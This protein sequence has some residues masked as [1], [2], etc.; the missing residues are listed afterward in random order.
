LHKHDFDVFHYILKGKIKLVT[1]L[2]N[3][4]LKENALIYLPKNSW[5]GFK[6]LSRTIMLE[7]GFN[8]K[9]NG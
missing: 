7:I 9:N 6:S 1:K 5:H 4:V 8:Y 2:K 3:F